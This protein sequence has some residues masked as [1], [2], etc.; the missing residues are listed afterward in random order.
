MASVLMTKAVEGKKAGEENITDILSN[1][2]LQVFQ[3]IGSGNSTREIASKLHVSIKTIENHRA[4]I[5][6]KLNLKNSI[7][8]LQKAT[9][10]DKNSE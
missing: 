4:H 6:E 1:R 5:K 7:E 9:L 10:W 3:M 2:E 8:L